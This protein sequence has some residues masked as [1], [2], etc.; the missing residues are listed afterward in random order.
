MAET[1]EDGLNNQRL[2]ELK[3][4]V[5]RDA[6]SLGF[7]EVRVTDTDLSAHADRYQ[8]W[9]DAGHHGEMGYL[10]E[11]ADKRMHPEALVEGACRVIVARMDYLPEG[12][13]PVRVLEQP[14][15]GYISRYATGRDYHKV[16]RRRLAKVASNLNLSV[17]EAMQDEGHRYRAFADSAPVLEKALAVKAGHG[18]V[19][20][21]S[22]VLNER[23]GSW[24]FLGEIF[25]N[26]PLPVDDGL[27]RDQCGACRACITVCPTDAIIDGRTIDA[28]RCIS[29]LTIEHKSAIPEALRGSL[30]NRIFGC[31]DCQLYCPWNR[32]ATPTREADFKPRAWL[33]DTPLE[34]LF[35]WSE[36]TFLNR[37]EGTPIR[38]LSFDQWQRNLAVAL[39]NGPATPAVIEALQARLPDASELVAEHIRWALDQLSR[40]NVLR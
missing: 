20:R 31:D 39:G 36:E 16:V 10:T 29:Y 5:V 19:G 13:D 24:F 34:A 27:A 22:L 12:T 3:A 33:L 11:N 2:T 4:Q 37:T 15:L 9:I 30:G 28:R 32:Q 17:Q 14:E 23:A 26:V 40:K 38:R 8:A 7:D 35:A 1:D 25:T 18:W 6:R 21:N